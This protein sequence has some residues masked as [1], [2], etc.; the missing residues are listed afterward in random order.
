[1]E[2]PRQMH[3]TN[4]PETDQMLGTHFEP[5]QLEKA[6]SQGGITSLNLMQICLRAF[7]DQ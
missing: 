5:V 1:M 7:P 3:K 2:A 6:S 4:E